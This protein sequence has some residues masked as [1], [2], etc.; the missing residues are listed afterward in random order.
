M[1]A[2]AR[3]AVNIVSAML[4]VVAVALVVVPVPTPVIGD[5]ALPI[6][7]A[8]APRQAA[9]VRAAVAAGDST[10]AGII[11]GN[12]FSSSR[13]APAT[14]FVPP[15]S[16][17]ALGENVSDAGPMMTPGTTSPAGTSATGAA[18]SVADG[19]SGDMTSDNDAVPALYGIVSV[20]GVRHALLALRSGEPPRLL[21]AGETHAGYRVVAIQTDRVTLQ[22]TRGTRTLRMA[23]PPRDS[24][25][26]S[27]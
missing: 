6:S 15:G 12:V 21:A 1:S 24:T 23:P 4:G 16:E 10:E 25:G 8:D 13:R 19:A 3:R 20:D 22:S 2:V 26:K 7:M 18:A 17:T 5:T 14:R 27:P 11:D 9:R